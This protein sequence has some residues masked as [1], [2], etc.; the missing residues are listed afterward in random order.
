MIKHFKNLCGEAAAFGF[1]GIIFGRRRDS[2]AHLSSRPT[3]RRRG[4]DAMIASVEVVS[5]GVAGWHTHPGDELS[6]VI[7]GQGT[8]LPARRGRQRLG[9]A[10]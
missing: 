8:L 10:S 1:V 3:G 2:R 9:T 4:R 5:D 7:E 6:H